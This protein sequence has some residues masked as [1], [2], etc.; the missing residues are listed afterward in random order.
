[1]NAPKTVTAEPTQLVPMEQAAPLA[2]MQILQQA[3]ERGANP[4]TLE[5]LLSLQERWQKNE[6][7]MAF[8]DAMSKA[9]AELPVIVK[10]RTVGYESKKAGA[11]GTTYKHA[12]FAQVARTVDPILTR[13]GLSYR[14]RTESV[15]GQA[16]VAVTCIVEHAAGHSEE[17]TLTA[18]RD[19]SGSKNNIQ[20]IGSTVTY[21]QRYTLMAALGLAAAADDDAVKADDQGVIDEAQADQI[22]TL[23]TESKANL[24]G[25]LKWAGAESIADIPK[26]KFNDAVAMLNAKKNQ[27]KAEA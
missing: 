20:A 27:K 11:A 21:L 23:V 26:A 12:D 2:P 14:F 22:R 16:S 6:A 17:T 3:I 8:A 19:T 4:E 15:S 1:M 18:E 7:R 9:K 24:E 13:H 25:F 5:K 10:N